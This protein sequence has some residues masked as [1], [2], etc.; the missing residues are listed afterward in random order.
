[1]RFSQNAQQAADGRVSWF[2][3]DPFSRMIRSGE[4]AQVFASLDANAAYAFETDAASWTSRYIY[5]I[6][7]VYDIDDIHDAGESG[8]SRE[9]GTRATWPVGRPTRVEQNTDADAAAE[10]H[11]APGLRPRGARHP[12]AGEPSIRYPTRISSIAMICPVR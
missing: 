2:A 8:A 10:V 6:D 12:Q 7:D 3:Y 5:D 1:M 9:S 11:N 4:V